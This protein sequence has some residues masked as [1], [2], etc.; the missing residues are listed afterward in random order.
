M[1]MLR[2]L[3]VNENRVVSQTAVQWAE[4]CRFITMSNTFH[5]VI[6]HIIIKTLIIATLKTAVEMEKS[7]GQLLQI[8]WKQKLPLKIYNL[9]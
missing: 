3:R 1:M 6:R 5:I 7:L 2:A 4:A 8:Y 9:N